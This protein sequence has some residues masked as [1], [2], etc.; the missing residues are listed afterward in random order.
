MIDKVIQSCLRQ[1]F[2][3]LIAL[4]GLVAYGVY[5]S[6][7]LQVDA[8]P[9]VTN[10]Q[11]QVYTTW[12]GMSPEEVEKQVTFP[13][14][15]Q[16]AGLPDMTELR[17][18]SRFGFSLITVVFADHVDLYFAR[19]L[20]LER[21]IA[22]KE[23]LPRGSDP[24]LGPIATGLS[25]IYQYTLEE[26]NAPPPASAGQETARLIRLRTIQDAIVRPLLKTVPGVTDINS[27]GGY[28]KQYQV[29]VDPDR[30]R[31]FDLSLKQ[32]FSA[33]TA[34]N[35]NA[36]GNIL[37]KGSEQALVRGLGLMQ[38][39]QDIDAVVLKEVNGTPVLV[40]DVA[41][42]SE[43]PATRWGAVLKDGKREAVAGIVLMIRGGS[44][45]EV[46]AAVKD[47]VAQL[48]AGGILPQGVTLKAFYDRTGLV[49]DCINTVGRAI[50]E[51]VLLVILVVYLFL[52]SFRGALV[53]ALTLPL[54][55][56]ATF[57]AMRQVDLSANL[58][59]LGGLAIS[60]GMIV[61]STII[62]VENVMHRLGEMPPEGNF[63]R[64]VLNAVL[65]V[66]KPSLFGELIIA[67][68]FLPIMTLQGMEGK[69]FAPLAFTVVIALLASL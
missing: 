30:L 39:V 6:L 40:K 21:L 12:P 14:E 55:A 4:A 36:G 50:A 2:L 9:D 27:F 23:K 18:V 46:V 7:K 1:R 68:T 3:V 53:I 28:V 62:Q 13:I 58:M 8:F 24:V 22:A 48:N 33:L 63:G 42:V 69:M 65:E 5:A 49:K 66:R 32:V 26:E 45:R 56:L 51:G 35:A 54:V 15:V 64:T 31:K 59:S 61:D 41:T 38:S 57:I 20:V 19:Q 44:G 60:I 67:L 37:E 17:S 52:R 25:E 16:L 10:V 34:S 43:G 47:K 11:V 29:Q